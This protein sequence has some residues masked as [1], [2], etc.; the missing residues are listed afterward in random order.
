MTLTPTQEE[1]IRLRF[2][3]ME[4]LADNALRID[5]VGERRAYLRG[6]YRRTMLKGGE[7]TDEAEADFAT[8]FAVFFE[9][10]AQ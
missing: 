1:T 5:D 10:E 8:T 2:R 6:H 3:N 7:W 4:L 9:D